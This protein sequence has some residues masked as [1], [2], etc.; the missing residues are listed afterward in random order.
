MKKQAVQSVKM[1]D[2]ADRLEVGRCFAVGVLQTLWC[3]A[4]EQAQDGLVSCSPRVLA[5]LLDYH[6][7]GEALVAALVG[8]RWLD[9]RPEGGWLIHDWPEHC[10]DAVHMALARGKRW[11]ADGSAPKINRLT[12]AERAAAEAFYGVAADVGAAGVGTEGARCAHG[13]RT[14]GAPTDNRLPL[15]DGSVKNA[16]TDS[17]THD[18]RV[19]KGIVAAGEGVGRSVGVSEKLGGSGQV[20]NLEAV[21][22][23]LGRVARRLNAD[24]EAMAGRKPGAG[25]RAAAGARSGG[26]SGVEAGAGG[27]SLVGA[28]GAPEGKAPRRR[29]LTAEQV[30]EKAGQIVRITGE[31]A[32]YREWWGDVVRRADQDASHAA[33]LVEAV[34]YAAMCG[35]PAQRRAKDLGELKRPGAFIAKRLMDAGMRLP[36]KPAVRAARTDARG[37]A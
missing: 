26:G 5:R 28:V 36:P 11:F 8:S 12:G 4:S 7:D 29:R 22:E 15:T 32:V 9:A 30:A 37:V 6:G 14:E 20:P 21:G 24:A 25:G 1:A 17:A 3:W 16:D 31:A 13:V 10:E 19:G 23:V 27:S 35:D 33:A 2:L 18:R 34:Q